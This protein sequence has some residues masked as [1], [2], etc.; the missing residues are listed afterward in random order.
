MVPRRM[1]EKKLTRAESDVLAAI[2]KLSSDGFPPTKKDLV[3]EL[4]MS[5]R[6]LEKHL[7]S[8]EEKGKI[9]TTIIGQA[10]IY[11][12]PS[13]DSSKIKNF[14]KLEEEISHSINQ[15]NQLLGDLRDPSREEIS[16]WINRDEEDELFRTIYHKVKE[17]Y[18]LTEPT[19][20]DKEIC[21]MELKNKINSAILVN[22]NLDFGARYRDT[23]KEEDY[24]SKN[25][26][27]LSKID[28]EV[29]RDGPE[30]TSVIFQYP[31]KI[32]S[33]TG[34]MNYTLKFDD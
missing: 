4:D 26:E 20:K 18:D 29:N 34:R 32:R 19:V 17:E 9:A 15:L 1:K 2:T 8:I 21:E 33:F 10:K 11:F 14:N 25:E 28:V 6:T 13:Y 31:K 30:I 5:Q 7:P 12:T 24:Y 3:K 16:D 23:E 27:I 22:K